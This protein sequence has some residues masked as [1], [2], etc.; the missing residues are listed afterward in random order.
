MAQLKMN[1]LSRALGRQVDVNVIIPTYTNM[2]QTKG[3]T[4]KEI[5]DPD[6]K[7]KVLILL[8]GFSGDCND[9]LRF[10]NVLRYAED[11]DF[12]ILMPSGD[13]CFYY[14]YEPGPKYRTFIAEELLQVARFMF[15]I[16]ERYEDTYIG[17][18][19]M[20]AHGSAMISLAYPEVFSKVYCMSGA[21]SRIDKNARSTSLNWFGKEKSV[22]HQDS[23]RLA[24][25]RKDTI[26]DAYYTADKNAKEG[27]PKAKYTFTIGDKDFLLDRTKEFYEY[28]K[29]LGYDATLEI[30]PG[31]GHE[32]DFW[33]MKVKEAL[34]KTL[35]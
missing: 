22:F 3:K 24:A 26:E 29:K 34:E 12:V 21:P 20:G 28:M 1:Y 11:N 9:Y 23:A 7:F 2:S 35:K 17:G 5:Y 13:N 8:H 10:T 19:S 16:S 33:D 31:Y 25:E 14:D 4:I 18:L 32:W 30:V 6:H 15:P 27:K